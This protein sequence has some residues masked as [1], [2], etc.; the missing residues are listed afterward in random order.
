MLQKVIFMRGANIKVVFQKTDMPDGCHGGRGGS[1]LQSNGGPQTD[2]LRCFRERQFAGQLLKLFG[3]LP[4]AVSSLQKLLEH[5][6]YSI[7]LHLP[8]QGHSVLVFLA[9]RYSQSGMGKTKRGNPSIIQCLYIS[10]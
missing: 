4:A 6:H 7:H 3:L 5:F 10:P 8:G 9:P 1:L 2:L